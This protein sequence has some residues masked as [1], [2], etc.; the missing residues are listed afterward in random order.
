MMGPG[1]PGGRGPEKWPAHHRETPETSMRTGPKHP[2]SKRAKKASPGRWGLLA[3]VCW[4]RPG[5]APPLLNHKVHPPPAP[6]L[7]GIF[8]RAEEQPGGQ[9]C[10]SESQT[11]TRTPKTRIHITS[12]CWVGPCSPKSQE[13]AAVGHSP[14]VQ[15]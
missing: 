11:K 15:P 2:T 12:A 14:R 4:R 5:L 13:T 1:P 9:D 10:L 3:G 6:S 7:S 8:S